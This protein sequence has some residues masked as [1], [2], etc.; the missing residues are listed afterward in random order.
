MRLQVRR[1]TRKKQVGWPTRRPTVRA[2]RQQI[3]DLTETDFED[4]AH[5]LL[6]TYFAPPSGIEWIGPGPPVR[7]HGGRPG[8]APPHPWDLN[9]IVRLRLLFEALRFK[10]R[11]AQ[12]A[13]RRK[14]DRA[15]QAERVSWKEWERDTWV[16]L[17]A[18]GKQRRYEHIL[19][20]I[21]IAAQRHPV[22]RPKGLTLADLREMRLW[23]QAANPS[24][25]TLHRWSRDYAGE[26]VTRPELHAEI[27]RIHLRIQRAVR[28][29]VASNP[30]LKGRV[31]IARPSAS[32]A[33]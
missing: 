17:D 24:R 27:L 12:R 14:R 16:E 15:V 8:P 33:R 22:P 20:K 5:Y 30:R 6:H 1:K 31:R 32:P 2:G 21:Q 10:A 3:N 13:A 11:A 19:E 25:S 26:R 18:E 4:V 9:G 7:T 28:D 23:P 29:L